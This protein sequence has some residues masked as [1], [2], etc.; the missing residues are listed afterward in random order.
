[1]ASA[2]QNGVV[3]FPS[4][5]F[6]TH[7]R[8]LHVFLFTFS[9]H[10]YHA[11]YHTLPR[12]RSCQ[13]LSHSLQPLSVTTF[14]L[15]SHQHRHHF[16]QVNLSQLK[17]HFWEYQLS[18]VINAQFKRSNRALSKRDSQRSQPTKICCAGKYTASF[19]TN[20]RY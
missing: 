18:V 9:Q 13:T 8:G 11:S 6:R 2:R 5:K 20:F 14:L 16:S 10:P 19:I 12:G 1:M 17:C 3:V 15:P 4:G 7:G